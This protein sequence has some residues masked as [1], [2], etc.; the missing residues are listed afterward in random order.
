MFLPHSGQCLWRQDTERPRSEKGP[1]SD[2][3]ADRSLSLRRA[4]G[5]PRPPLPV[6]RPNALYIPVAVRFFPGTLKP[7]NP[8][9]TPHGSVGGRRDLDRT[10]HRLGLAPA[11]PPCCGLTARAMS[12][13]LRRGN[14]DSC[15]GSGLSRRDSQRTQRSPRGWL[16]PGGSGGRP[17]P[18]PRQPASSSSRGHR[19]LAPL[20]PGKPALAPRPQAG[21]RA[22]RLRAA[23]PDAVSLA[24]VFEVEP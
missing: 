1:S 3:R 6:P 4:R 14:G 9:H 13:S 16:P 19:P 2:R 17:R 11:R 18:R 24:R 7:D 8:A 15:A 22:Q 21:G 12:S 10:P 23:G 20:G 5:S